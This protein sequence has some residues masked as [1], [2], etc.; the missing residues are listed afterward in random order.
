M[1]PGKLF[2][3]K[4]S[5]STLAVQMSL[6]IPKNKILRNVSSSFDRTKIIKLLTKKD[7]KTLYGILMAILHPDDATFVNMHVQILLQEDP[8]C[9]LMYKPIGKNSSCPGLSSDFLLDYMNSA[10]AKML[11]MY[12]IIVTIDSTHGTNQYSFQLTTL[13]VNDS[14]YDDFSIGF[15]HSYKTH[16][17]TF[18][19]FFKE[20]RKRVPNFKPIIKPD[21]FFM[22]DDYPAYFN[23]FKKIFNVDTNFHLC[24]WHVLRA[25]NQKLSSD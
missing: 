3:S 1:V 20:V 19:I 9:L 12:G 11:K 21:I 22:S 23:T 17:E 14:H 6:G 5:R 8:E 4:D 18:M 13:L 10:Q 2:L 7:L 15:I 25:W 16:K 24:T